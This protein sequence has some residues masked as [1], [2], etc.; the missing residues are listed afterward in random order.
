MIFLEVW[1]VEEWPTS[2][3]PCVWSKDDMD[4]PCLTPSNTVLQWPLIPSLLPLL[5]WV[6]TCGERTSWKVVC[7]HFWVWQVARSV[8]PWD[9]GEM[10]EELLLQL[11][12]Q[13]FAQTSPCSPPGSQSHTN[14]PRACRVVLV[15]WVVAFCE[16]WLGCAQQLLTGIVLTRRLA[17]EL[18]FWVSPVETLDQ[19]NNILRDWDRWCEFFSK[20]FQNFKIFKFFFK[21]FIFFKFSSFFFQNFFSIFLFFLKKKKIQNSHLYNDS[22]NFNH[23]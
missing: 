9:I 19:L 2:S 11:C 8:Q 15:H 13:L 7:G 1:F 22:R 3:C 16:V 6:S 4:N 23:N 17:Q 21:N 12:V 18:G 20:F 10:S 5:I 14:V